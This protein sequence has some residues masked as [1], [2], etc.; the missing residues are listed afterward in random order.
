MKPPPFDYRRADSAEHALELLCRDAG[1]AR[2]LAGGQSLVPMM[3]LRLARPAILIDIARL[4]LAGIAAAPGSIELGAL[5][6][7]R[8]VIESREIAALAPIIPAAMRQIAHPAI[9]NAGTA[10]GS[11]AYADPTAELAALLVLLDGEVIARST[12]ESRTIQAGEFFRG[13]F[14]TA[15]RDDEMITGLHFRPPAARHGS[16]F[17]EIAERDGDYAIAAVGVTLA[18]QGGRVTEARIVLSG[19]EARP[20]R[21]SEAERLLLGERPEGEAARAAATAAIA[22]RSAYGDIRA[23]AQYRLSLL[24][25][26]TRRAVE[27]AGKEALDGQA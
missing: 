15:L 23:T 5:A 8:A 10:G 26:L 13:A 16:A 1:D 25:T 22:G 19:A 11:I 6:R 2:L 9:R 24:E 21:A 3:N 18:A 20:V 14:E 12:R 27:Q 4:P 17:L 7:H